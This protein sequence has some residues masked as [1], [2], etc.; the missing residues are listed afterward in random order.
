V[1]FKILNAKVKST[2]VVGG[3][4]A[5]PTNSIVSNCL[6]FNS[7]I[8]DVRKTPRPSW[9][10]LVLIGARRFILFKILSAASLL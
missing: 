1:V 3:S 2:L 5:T 9:D 7:I 4:D 10:A 6:Y 8:Q